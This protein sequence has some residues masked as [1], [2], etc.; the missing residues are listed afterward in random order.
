MNLSKISIVAL[1][2]LGASTAD[3]QVPGI[4][5]PAMVPQVTAP[6]TP[7]SQPPVGRHRHDG[8]FLRMA[9]GPAYTATLLQGQSAR[10]SG[11]SST[12]S[13]QIGMSVSEH[14]ILHGNMTTNIATDPV[15]H[16]D[17]KVTPQ[18]NI[19]AYLQYGLGFGASYYFPT[20]TYLDLSVEYT[21]LGF[22][23]VG[24]PDSF[25]GRGIHLPFKVGHEWWVGD[26]W[27]IGLAAQFWYGYARSGG[28]W[29]DES[30]DLNF[31]MHT[32]GGGL[33]LSVTYD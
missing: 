13:L 25:A 22:S 18:D 24:L 33:L 26:N 9:L 29:Y 2:L 3:A 6:A 14:M 5:L 7:Q 8:F 10:L 17:S 27:G 28:D 20:N 1:V 23:H 12:L 30:S 16:V 21:E 32:F 19:D 11:I 4:Q 15:Y 31:N